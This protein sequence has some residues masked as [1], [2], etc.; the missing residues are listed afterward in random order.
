MKLIA[1][2]WK[3]NLT[4]SQT[5]EYLKKFIPLVEDIKDREILICPSF[6]SLCVAQDMLRETHIKLGAQNCY[7]EPKGAFTGEVFS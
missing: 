1:A 7:Y 3:M 4:P 6:T 5:G 2:N